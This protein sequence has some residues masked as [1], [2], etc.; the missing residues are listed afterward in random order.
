M[1]ACKECTMENKQKDF[2]LILETVGEPLQV[3]RDVT[4]GAN[5]VGEPL[6]ILRDVTGGANRAAHNVKRKQK[7][8]SH[9]V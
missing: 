9:Y 2:Y 4:G 1:L 6:K 3:L 5:T 7:V 8:M